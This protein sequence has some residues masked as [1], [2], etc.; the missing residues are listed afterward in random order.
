[1]LSRPSRHAYR[2]FGCIGDTESLCGIFTP[3]RTSFNLS[4]AEMKKLVIGIVIAVIIALVGLVPL[5]EVAY[6]ATEPLSYESEGYLYKEQHTDPR[7]IHASVQFSKDLEE[8]TQ[9]IKQKPKPAEYPVGYASVVNRDNVSGSFTVHFIFY[10]SGDQ[11]SEDVTLQLKPNEL[12]E[13][14]YRAIY[15][16]ANEDEWSGEYEVIADMKTVTNYKKV[17][18]LRYL[19]QN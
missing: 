14:Q 9:A 1:M 10:S 4:E 5:K 18:L 12:G 8:V 11:Y 7:F 6:T 3:G 19:L 13:A 2:T 15:I 17:T 16:D